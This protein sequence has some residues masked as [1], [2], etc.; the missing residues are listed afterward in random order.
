MLVP[1]AWDQEGG[2]LSHLSLGSSHTPYH[3]ILVNDS[4]HIQQWSHEIIVPS[5]FTAILF[6]V[7]MLFDVYT[8]KSNNAFFRIYPLHEAMH[9]YIRTAPN[10]KRGAL[11]VEVTWLE[12]CGAGAGLGS[13]SRAGNS[14]P[15]C[16]G[17]SQPRALTF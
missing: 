15:I 17:S 14:P 7:N 13:C 5:D 1:V 9:N 8:M 11:G 3:S 2:L 16:S 12:P 4:P 6:C 10:T